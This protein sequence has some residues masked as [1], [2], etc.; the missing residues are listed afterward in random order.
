M[1]A[2]TDFRTVA[3]LAR[4]IAH[5]LW[6]LPDVAQV[7]AIPESGRLPAALLALAM[8]TRMALVCAADT[9]AAPGGSRSRT[10][11]TYKL[12]QDGTAAAYDESLAV[13]CLQGIINR[14]GPDVYVLSRKNSR[15]EFWLDVLSKEGRWLGGRE[16]RAARPEAVRQP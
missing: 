8:A 1:V 7:V 11:Y 16:P 6:R 3:D 10:L 2:V 14:D 15:P 9:Q 4:T 5:N 12:A 13:A